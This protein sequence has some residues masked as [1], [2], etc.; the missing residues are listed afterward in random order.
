MKFEI[1]FNWEATP[2]MYEKLESIKGVEFADNDE[3]GYLY[4]EINTLE[5]LKELDDKVFEKLPEYSMIVGF[6][7]PTIYL[8]K[9]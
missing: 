5:E 9:V 3:R 2:E 6:D 7:S 8:D 1:D 4:I